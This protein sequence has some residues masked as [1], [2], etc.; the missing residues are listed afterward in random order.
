MRP[1]FEKMTQIGKPL[2][3]SK[4][5]STEENVAEIKKIEQELA[6]AIEKK[7]SAGLPDQE[8]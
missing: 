7:K 6:E 2:S 8:N 3:Q 1:Y 4:I 5:K